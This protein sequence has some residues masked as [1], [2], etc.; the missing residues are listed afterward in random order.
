MQYNKILQRM[1][2]AKR[3]HKFVTWQIECSIVREFLEQKQKRREHKEG[4][5]ML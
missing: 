2:S 4:T 3:V 5:E 1:L